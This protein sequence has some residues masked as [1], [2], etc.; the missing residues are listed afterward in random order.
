MTIRESVIEAHLV[1]RVKQAGGVAYK[2]VSPGTLGIPDRIVLLPGSVVV[3]VEM[4]APGKKPTP[5][6]DRQH[7]KLMKLGMRVVVLDSIA[8]V[9]KFVEGFA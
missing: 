7:V 2:W 5:M 4:K 1:K 6:Q 8:G 3:F 9:D